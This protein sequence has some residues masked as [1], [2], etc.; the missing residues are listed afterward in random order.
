MTI[1]AKA[2]ESKSFEPIPEGSY[3]ARL[4]QIIHVGNVEG[5]E[6]Q[7]QN[8]VRLT[9]EI[10]ELTREF[11]EGEG[12][13]PLVISKE[14][15]LSTHEKANL[16]KVIEALVGTA[17][18]EKEAEDFDVEKLVGDTGL[19]T[20]KQKTGDR[21]KYAYVDSV[22]VLPKSMKCG[23]QVNKNKVQNYDDF[24]EEFHASLPDFLREK[25]ESS[26]EYRAMAGED[27]VE[28]GIPF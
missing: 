8:K 2:G 5:W 16:R 21:G 6:Q 18:S 27:A 24:D 4:Y 15:T 25:I 23:K 7:I 11:K 17:L 28:D 3:A 20:I 19:L 1:T 13:K 12:E 26:E 14:Y 10:P 9:F 22:T